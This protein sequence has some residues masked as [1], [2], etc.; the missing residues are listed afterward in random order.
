MTLF[1]FSSPHFPAFSCLCILLFFLESLPL[2][3]YPA[4]SSSL[5]LPTSS[6]AS[7]LEETE[8]SWICVGRD[9][10]ANLPEIECEC[11][12]GLGFSS[13][14]LS[15]SYRLSQWERI[16]GQ[17]YPH[18][19]TW[20]AVFISQSP[21]QYDWQRQDKAMIIPYYPWPFVTALSHKHNC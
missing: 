21:T 2:C 20:R 10:A 14:G 11:I 5:S 3:P 7:P 16:A 9:L 12:A 1:V 4:Y 13:M 15:M 17:A 18:G 19:A 6:S 8:G